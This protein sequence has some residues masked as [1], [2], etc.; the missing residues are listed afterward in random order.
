MN[1]LN[2]VYYT[3]IIIIII[4]SLNKTAICKS[5]I[6]NRLNKKEIN[7]FYIISKI[8]IKGNKT[9]KSQIIIRELTFS[10]GDT[11]HFNNLDSHINRSK[12]SLLNTSLFNYVTINSSILN[13]NFIHISIIVEERWYTW[14]YPIFEHADRNF[15]SFIYSKDYSKINYGFHFVRYNFR[16]RNENLSIKTRFGYKEQFMLNYEI[17]YINK[18]Q[19]FGINIEY[20]YF[21][22][23]ETAYNTNNNKLIFYKSD[24]KYIKKEII[25]A[26]IATYRIG[27]YKKHKFTIN[28]ITCSVADT[29]AILNPEYFG[30][31]STNISFFK[32]RY[33]YL[34]NY[35]DSKAYPLNGYN[36]KALLTNY[37]TIIKQKNNFNIFSLELTYNK[38]FNPTEKIYFSTGI[39][40][41]KSNNNKQAFYIKKALGYETYLRGFE[42]YVINGQD[43]IINQSTFKYEL[44]KPRI[45]KF[46]FIPL[47]KFNKIHY[48]FYLNLFFDSGYV[49]DKYT[50]KSDD[51]VNEF[52]FSYGIGLDFVT[53][54]DK[55]IRF[56]YSINKYLESGF[57]MHFKT[58]F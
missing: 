27:L 25:A 53:Y 50:Q 34:L 28:S 5:Q 19:N 2:H 32:F 46:D 35:L 36:F 4:I 49:Y 16:G 33:H 44:I 15:S 55:I 18:K 11:I 56:E 26:L 43:Y 54:Y 24:E 12:E 7:D 30:K 3:F 14:P 51:M 21:Q 57:Y 9:T 37:S 6:I 20:S 22:M 52:L 17:P 23:H 13:T 48:A 1:K 45:K 8:E 42:L 10:I 58:P 47:T 31:E 29:I 41:K 39:K 38:Y 40:G